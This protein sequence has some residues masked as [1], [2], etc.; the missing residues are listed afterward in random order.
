[1]GGKGRRT[2]MGKSSEMRQVAWW[3]GGGS[4]LRSGVEPLL[5]ELEQSKISAV[6]Q[7]EG[8]GSGSMFFRTQPGCCER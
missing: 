1:M 6:F 5:F 7:R 3:L 4:S 2:W 8:C